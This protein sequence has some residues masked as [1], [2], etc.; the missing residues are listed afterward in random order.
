MSD[1]FNFSKKATHDSRG[2]DALYDENEL[3]YVGK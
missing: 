1:I 3:Y 2:I